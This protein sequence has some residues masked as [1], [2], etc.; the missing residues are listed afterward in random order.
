M[1]KPLTA[2]ETAEELGYSAD[3]F[4]R[5][6]HELELLGLTPIPNRANARP[7]YDRDLVK[8]YKLGQ[9]T[10]ARRAPADNDN[11]ET[12]EQRLARRAAAVAGEA[13]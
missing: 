6:R 2:A 13:R 12:M 10:T 8:R 7:R 11:E 9:L 4:Y 1:A 3:W 5:H